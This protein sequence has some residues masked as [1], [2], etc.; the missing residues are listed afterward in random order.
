MI[1]FVKRLHERWAAWRKRRLFPESRVLVEIVDGQARC[2][3]PKEEPGTVSFSLLKTVLIETTDAGPFACDLFWILE[4]STGARL[5]VPKGATGEDALVAYLLE[6]DG[7]NHMVMVV[8][9]GSTS[10]QIFECW[11]A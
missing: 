3:W 10:N 11:A 8:A 7:F 4:D 5:R 9:M 1:A 2:T 6:L